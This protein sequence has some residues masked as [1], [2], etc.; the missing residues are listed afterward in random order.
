M[1]EKPAVMDLDLYLSLRQAMDMLEPEQRAALAL[2]FGAEFSH[3]EAAIAL[4]LPLEAVKA[5]VAHGRARLRQLLGEAVDCGSDR[6]PDD[7]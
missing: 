6:D 5:H 4:G 3:A 2:C 1:I 7:A